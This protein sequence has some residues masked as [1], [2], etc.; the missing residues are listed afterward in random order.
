MADGAKIF[1]LTLSAAVLLAS[2]G[3]P[4]DRTPALMPA[5][6]GPASLNLRQELS[7]KAA[8][9]A[10]VHHGEPLDVLE[11]KRRFLKVRTAAG[12]IGWTEVNQLLAAEQ[13]ADLRRLAETSARFPGQGV[14]STFE[15]LN[16]HTEPNRT[17]PSF[18]Q[19]PE[20]GKVDVIGHRVAPRIQAS[21]VLLTPPPAKPKPKK[22]TK[23]KGA[24]KIP[25]PPPPTAPPPPA[26]WLAMS[27]P[28]LE[29][30]RPPKSR[31]IP[32]R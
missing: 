11:F 5:F 1:R 24:P 19:I 30:R 6:V 7:T 12:I 21:A 9:S 27:R 17:S 16:V 18:V 28:R 22:K 23:E 10:T 29:L 3:P 15:P 25:P 26:N 2:C 20:G 14:A 8:V 31:P 13:M 4:Q 32:R